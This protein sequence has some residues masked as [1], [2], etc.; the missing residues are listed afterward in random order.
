MLCNLGLCGRIHIF[1]EGRPLQEDG[2][3]S[4]EIVLCPKYYLHSSLCS[5][6]YRVTSLDEVKG[7]KLRCYRGQAVT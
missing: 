1:L 5:Y 6:Y 2:V 3:H 7:H 4:K